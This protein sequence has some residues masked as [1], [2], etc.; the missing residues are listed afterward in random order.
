MPTQLER[1]EELVSGASSSYDAF[2]RGDSL[3]LLQ[4]HAQQPEEGHDG[5]G[6]SRALAPA[7]RTEKAKPPTAEELERVRAQVIA[8]SGL[9]A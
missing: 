2:T 3:F 9:R 4:R 8:G 1:G 6:R 5:P 7:G